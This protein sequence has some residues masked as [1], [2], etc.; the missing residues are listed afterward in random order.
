M[1]DITKPIIP[2]DF[3]TVECPE[4]GTIRGRACSGRW[5]CNPRQHLFHKI[6][7]IE[8]LAKVWEP[9]DADNAEHELSEYVDG[10]N[11]ALDAIA[12]RLRGRKP[13]E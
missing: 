7:E 3:T 10:W 4:C 13:S 12:E 1:S 2:P 6:A 8:G 11:D 5:A 9:R